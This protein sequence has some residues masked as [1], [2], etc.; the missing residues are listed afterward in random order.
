MVLQETSFRIIELI[1]FFMASQDPKAKTWQGTEFDISNWHYSD[2]AFQ[3]YDEGVCV[4]EPKRQ[5]L[6]KAR[7]EY[8]TQVEKEA[9]DQGRREMIG[10]IES[11]FRN[12]VVDDGLSPV[13]IVEIL[14]HFKR[15]SRT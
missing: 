13:E 10:E 12:R 8:I 6:L 7:R 5:K 9:L 1:I 3:R 4:C 11:E 15:K 14:Q 2:C